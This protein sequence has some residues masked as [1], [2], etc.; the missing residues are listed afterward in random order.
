M[1]ICLATAFGSLEADF[2]DELPQAATVIIA[3][4][5]ATATRGALRTDYS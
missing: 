4:A 1:V 2:E 5:A 3:R